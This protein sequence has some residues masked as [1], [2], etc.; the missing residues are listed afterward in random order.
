VRIHLI[1]T[2]LEID[3][4]NNTLTVLA[5]DPVSVNIT[6]HDVQAIMISMASQVIKPD[7]P[8]TSPTKNGHV[9]GRAT[10]YA[11]PPQRTRRLQRRPM[12]DK[13]GQDLID[14]RAV[15]ILD[16]MKKRGHGVS[17]KE[18]MKA[19]GYPAG[20]TTLVLRYLEKTGRSFRSKS[21]PCYMMY[22]LTQAAAQKASDDR[23]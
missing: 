13:D 8:E 7:R 5:G 20:G 23:R 15:V 19:T 3:T 6:P 10:I 9:L 2:H 18:I 17:L 14:E 4:V 1:E 12:P 21:A 22:G 16:F 11:S